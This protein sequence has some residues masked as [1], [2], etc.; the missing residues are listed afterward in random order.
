MALNLEQLFNFFE[1]LFF[2]YHLIFNYSFSLTGLLRDSDCRFFRPYSRLWNCNIISLLRI[3]FEFIS[4]WA[5]LFHECVKSIILLVIK[6]CHL[7]FIIFMLL[8]ITINL[9]NLL[10][11]QTVTFDPLIKSEYAILLF[12]I[13]SQLPWELFQ[14]LE[15]RWHIR[16]QFRCFLLFFGFI[17]TWETLILYETLGERLWG[18]VRYRLIFYTDNIICF[19]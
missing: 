11:I 14:R 9:K 17:D 13:G 5:Y 10:L 8:A 1:D 18:L 7:L 16:C 12:D 2:E 6:R 19:R 15:S 4:L 3:L